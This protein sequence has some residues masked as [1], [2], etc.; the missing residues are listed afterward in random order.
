M[1][2][3]SLSENVFDLGVTQIP[4]FKKLLYLF[5]S[6]GAVAVLVWQMVHEW[7]LLLN[8][9]SIGELKISFYYLVLFFVSLFLDFVGVSL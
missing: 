1:V 2:V 4:L 6:V 8:F 5:E 3:I 9:S 7:L